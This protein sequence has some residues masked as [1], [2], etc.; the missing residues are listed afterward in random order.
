MEKEVSS[1]VQYMAIV[2]VSRF[3][4]HTLFQYIYEMYIAVYTLADE[5]AGQST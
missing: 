1:E 5:R 4:Q 3:H 2:W